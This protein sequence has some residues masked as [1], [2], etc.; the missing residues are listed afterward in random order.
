MKHNNNKPNLNEELKHHQKTELGR[1]MGS[2]PY[3]LLLLFGIWGSI[4]VSN[5][6]RTHEIAISYDVTSSTRGTAKNINS[7]SL[8]FLPVE[9]NIAGD[10]A[11]DEIHFLVKNM[12]KDATYFIRFG[13]GKNKKKLKNK[14][15]I[16]TYEQPGVYHV[17]VIEQNSRKTEIVKSQTLDI[18]YP[19]NIKGDYNEARY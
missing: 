5:E 12:K 14:H 10:E 17:D 6:H 11:Q 19:I 2:I 16:H 8:P 9:L 1:L 13:D 3:I 18:G 7:P 15:I 4:I